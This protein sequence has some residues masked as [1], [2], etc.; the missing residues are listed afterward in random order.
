MMRR[1]AIEQALDLARMPALTRGSA[2]PPIPQNIVELMQVAANSPAACS[3]AATATGEPV[4]VLVEAARFYLQQSLFRADAD[5]NRILGIRAG[6]TRDVARQHM[7]LLLQWLHPD[8]NSGLEAIYAERVLRAWR[9]VS[10]STEAVTE[11]ESPLPA[12][13]KVN[14]TMR[15]S[16]RVP[17]IKSPVERSRADIQNAYWALATWA[18]PGLVL[19]FLAL[20]SL[21]RYIGSDQIASIIRLP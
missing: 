15:P 12:S 18:F 17:W 10:G 8:R 7:R 4:E 16:I 14:G 13:V 5:S 2:V 6:E 11:I 1:H 19:G 9:E 20:W 21:A 3:E